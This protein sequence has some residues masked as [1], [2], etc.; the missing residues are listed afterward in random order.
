MFA[1]KNHYETPSTL[2]N[3]F[4]LYLDLLIFGLIALYLD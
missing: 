1:G 3:I 2:S 4:Y